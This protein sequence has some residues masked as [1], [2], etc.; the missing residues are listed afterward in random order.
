MTQRFGIDPYAAPVTKPG[1]E[2][3]DEDYW[4]KDPVE[5][6]NVVPCFALNCE[7]QNYNCG[8]DT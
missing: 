3:A 6:G 7:E 2:N 8:Q 5:L 4:G 1:N